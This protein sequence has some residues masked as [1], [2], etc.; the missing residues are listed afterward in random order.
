MTKRSCYIMGLPAAGKTTYLA[1]LAYATKQQ[2][3]T[4]LRWK[5]F[6]GNHQYIND[7]S[8]E[9]LEGSVVSRTNRDNQ[10]LNIKLELIDNDSSIAY[11][12]TFPDISGETFLEQYESREMQRDYY[13][14]VQ[15]CDAVLLFI[16]PDNVKDPHFITEL[17]EELRVDEPELKREMKDDPT[18]VQLVELIQFLINIRRKTE[19]SLCMVVSAWDTVEKDF[20]KPEEYVKNELPLLWQYLY[21]NEMLRTQYFGISAQGGPITSEK[22][23]KEIVEKYDEPIKRIRVVNNYG[24]ICHDP[25]I[26][27]WNAMM[28]ENHDN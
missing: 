13:H 23:S 4:K 21:T 5:T 22:D 20:E 3:K 8:Y 25:S 11:E 6:T 15:Q 19:I 24:V 16:N 12:T 9:W 10:Q 18:E 14:L 26:I 1:A 7:L 27:L 17:E 28:E 2:G